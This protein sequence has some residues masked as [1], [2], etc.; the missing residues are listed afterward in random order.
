MS[1][2]EKSSTKQSSP[3]AKPSNKKPAE[4]SGLSFPGNPV[5]IL[6]FDTG[7]QNQTSTFNIHSH[8]PI[9]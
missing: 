9:R 7:N 1:A 3:R 2:K 4:I 8:V 6:L 5:K